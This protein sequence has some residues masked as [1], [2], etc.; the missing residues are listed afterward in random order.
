MLLFWEFLGR[1]FI[2]SIFSS[3]PI[4][5]FEG[6]VTSRKDFV[7][8]VIDLLESRNDDKSRLR[9]SLWDF[10][11]G[12]FRNL[13]A[14]ETLLG[15]NHDEGSDCNFGESG[16]HRHRSARENALQSVPVSSCSPYSVRESSLSSTKGSVKFDFP[17][18]EPT[19]LSTRA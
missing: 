1:V 10:D 6:N 9:Q 16:T 15:D 17:F 3:V 5:E 2:A 14:L 18:V 13:T 12:E 19:A 7:S 8:Q 4:I 11:Q